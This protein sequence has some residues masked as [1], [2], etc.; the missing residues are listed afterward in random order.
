VA[1]RMN[2]ITEFGKIIDPLADKIFV[3][4]IIISFFIQNKIPLWFF[5]LVIAK[6][7]LI[8]LGGLIIA[9]SKNS[10]PAS[11]YFGKA[12]VVSI[13]LTFLVILFEFFSREVKEYFLI[14]TSLLII[15]SFLIYLKNFISFL[16]LRS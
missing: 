13:S 2:Q 12:A 5:V 11:N 7:L 16:N 10:V 1:R 8:L 3:S 15:L 9:K 14:F 4:T 6:D